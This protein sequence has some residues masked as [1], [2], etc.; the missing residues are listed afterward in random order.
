MSVEPPKFRMT[1]WH[2]QAQLFCFYAQ[3]TVV[4]P[5]I[6]HKTALALSFWVY[7]PE[8]QA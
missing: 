3:G 8:E 7:S 4:V 2:C 1:D 5:R 6:L